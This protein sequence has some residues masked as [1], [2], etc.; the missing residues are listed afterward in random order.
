MLA[1]FLLCP[2]KGQACTRWFWPARLLLLFDSRAVKQGLIVV[3]LVTRFTHD[4]FIWIVDREL[5]SAVL[6]FTTVVAV[7]GTF[8]K[9][10]N[11]ILSWPFLLNL[12][13]LFLN[14]GSLLC[15]T[16]QRVKEANSCEFQTITWMLKLILRNFPLC[17]ELPNTPALRRRFAVNRQ[18]GTCMAAPRQV[19][20]TLG[21]GG[22]GAQWRR[23][24]PWHDV[25]LS[26][27][28]QMKAISIVYVGYDFYYFCYY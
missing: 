25:S 15:K 1:C 23:R 26:R 19:S 16:F 7:I 18:G 9:S 17:G 3:H 14:T 24:R 5:I 8:V 6:V 22:G 27:C 28:L 21:Y 11:T 12:D 10:F 20:T 4:F 2:R 13:E